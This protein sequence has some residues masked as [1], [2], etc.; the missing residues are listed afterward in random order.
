V[1]VLIRVGLV[2]WLVYDPGIG[3]RG[4]Q[5]SRGGFEFGELQ[6]CVWGGV[7]NPKCGVFWRLGVCDL[8]LS[9]DPSWRMWRTEARAFFF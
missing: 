8:V 4:F 9:A 1:V 7:K 6:G 2:R 3:I 5:D